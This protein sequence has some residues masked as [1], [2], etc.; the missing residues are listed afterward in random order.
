[1]L[2]LHAQQRLAAVLAATLGSCQFALT[3]AQFLLRCAVVVG[4]I[5]F[6][7]VAGG[8]QRG[9]THIHTDN[10]PCLGQRR[11]IL[12]FAGKAGVPAPCLVND[13]H[14]LDRAFQRTMPARGYTSDA[15]QLQAPPIHLRPN[16][17][18]RKIEAA[19]M[20]ATFE[21]RIAWCLA[22]LQPA[23]EGVKCFTHINR[24]R[25]QGLG[26]YRFSLRESFP[27]ESRLL[28]LIVFADA[29]LFQLPCPL[30]LGKTHVVEAA[31][32][33]QNSD[34]LAR[35]RRRRVETIL[36]CLEMRVRIVHALT[37]CVGEPV[38]LV[39]R[40]WHFL[41]YRLS[42]RCARRLKSTALS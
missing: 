30:A 35:L 41:F 4:V 16:A 9:N 38:G 22:C 20:V 29:A 18:L 2:A 15:V 36:E 21:A 7:T 33:V 31:A 17:V 39:L 3:A 5:H 23:K 37:S 19:K 27:V 8:E 24:Y 40:D 10:P 12:D 11:G 25:L 28:H 26:E 42:N 6:E 14:R 32:H 13:A 34:H 1:M